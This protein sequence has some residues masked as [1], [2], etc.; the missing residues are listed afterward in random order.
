MSN[1]CLNPSSLKLS[2]ATLCC[3]HVFH[4]VIE[5]NT[6]SFTTHRR[7]QADRVQELH[8]RFPELLAA[9]R[10]LAVFSASEARCTKPPQLALFSNSGLNITVP[11]DRAAPR[12]LQAAVDEAKAALVRRRETE[13]LLPYAASSGGCIILLLRPLPLG[14]SILLAE[15]PASLTRNCAEIAD[16]VS[17]SCTVSQSGDILCLDHT[18]DALSAD[19]PLSLGTL[20]PGASTIRVLRESELAIHFPKSSSWCHF[21]NT[22]VQPENLSQRRSL[23]GC[24]IR[25]FPADVSE[26]AAATACSGTTNVRGGQDIV[27]L[28]STLEGFSSL[29]KAVRDWLAA[30]PP[31]AAIVDAALQE[32]T[33]RNLKQHR[34]ELPSVPKHVKR[35]HAKTKE[36]SFSNEEI[37]TTSEVTP[38]SPSL[39]T[40]QPDSKIEVCSQDEIY[41]RELQP[42]TASGSTLKQHSRLHPT[43]VASRSA[44]REIKSAMAAATTV[45]QTVEE[46]AQQLR[47]ALASGSAAV[48]VHVPEQ[49]LQGQEQTKSLPSS[50]CGLSC[51]LEECIGCYKV[52]RA[53]DEVQ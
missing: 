53:S 10:E 40:K 2:C 27:L 33:L 49:Q 43:G 45:L 41:R 30:H 37:C 5:A 21:A 32:A 19:K 38:I 26:E 22:Q 52:G 31:Q 51:D 48:T 42:S 46:V 36:C 3:P 34:L 20:V 28:A 1:L 16:L 13:L 12:H 29:R 44:L 50:I 39:A 7:I 9:L 15:T 14:T 18:P 24:A 23:F 17:T 4:P 8:H 11:T 25:V 47:I 6:E 35:V